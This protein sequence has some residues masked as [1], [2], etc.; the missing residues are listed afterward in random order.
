M[1]GKFAVI[2]PCLDGRQRRVWLG[3]EARALGRGGVAAVSKAVK[4]LDQPAEA[5]P[6]GR[7]RRAGAGRPPLTRTDPGLEAAVEE[8]VG[9][10]TRGDPE[11]ST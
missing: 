9:P 11:S 1:A 3:V 5:A 8:L 4:E 6:V 2:G 10:A 7:V